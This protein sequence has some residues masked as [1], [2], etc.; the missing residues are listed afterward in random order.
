[1][2][3]LLGELIKILVAAG[4]WFGSVYFAVG[5]FL[6]DPIPLWCGLLNVIA[7]LFLIAATTRTEHGAWLFFYGPVGEEPGSPLIGLLW[8]VPA[9]FVML[10]LLWRLLLRFLGSWFA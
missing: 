1:M 3:K 4:L 6:P 10:G 5:A 7:G 8:G 2:G 9:V